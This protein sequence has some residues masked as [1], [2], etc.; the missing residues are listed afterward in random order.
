MMMMTLPIKHDENEDD[1][2]DDDEDDNTIV[3][4]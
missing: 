1:K 3:Y 4:C 2:D